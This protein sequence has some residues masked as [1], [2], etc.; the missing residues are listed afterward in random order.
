ML[1][2]RLKQEDI[3]LINLVRRQE[4]LKEIEPLKPDF[5]V[6]TENKDW[7]SELK[8]IAKESIAD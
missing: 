5:V 1:I 4:L 7:D 8:K 3:K 2:R 6:N